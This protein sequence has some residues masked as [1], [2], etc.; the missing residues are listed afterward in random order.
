[1][2]HVCGGVIGY[3]ITPSTEIAEL[4]EAARAEGVLN[5][6]GKHPFFF[7]TEGEHSAQSGAL[8][9]ALTGGQFISNASSSQGILYAMESHFVTVGKKIG[10]FV[11]QVAARVVSKHSLNVMAG[12][13]DVYA[14]LPSGYTILFGSNPQEAADLAAISYRTSALSLIPVANAMDGFAT[15]HVMSEARLPEPEL[16]REYLGDP[17]GRI[18]CPTVAQEMLFGAKGRVFQLATYLDRHA[19]DFPTDDLVALRAYLADTAEKIEQDNAGDLVGETAAWVPAELQP[20][21]RRQWIGAWEKGTRQL[22]PALVD[23]H[24]PGLTGPVQN[25]PDFQAG[26]VDHRTHF[27][28]AVPT[29][30]RQAMAEYSALSGRQYAPVHTYDCDDAD[31]IMVGLG[32]VTDDVRAVLPHLRAQGMKVGVVSVKLLQP[33]PEADLVAALSGAKAVTVLERS[34]DTALTRAVTQALFK[35]RAN[36]DSPQYE[37]IP[38]ISAPPRLTTAVFGLGGHDL[39]PRHTIAAFKQMA[40]GGKSPLLYLGSQFFSKD[41]SPEMAERQARLR[42]AYP[43]TELMALETEPNPAVLP[44]TALRIRFHSVGGYGTIATGKLLTD[45]LAGVLGMHSK[46]APKYGSEKSGAATNYYITLSPEPVLLTNAE[47]EDV[48]VVVSPDH[49][50][51]VHTNPLKGLV[52]GGTFI[53][54]SDL[55]PEDVWR[56]LPAYA[57]KAIRERGIRFLVVDAFAVAKQHAP[58][59]ELETRMMGIA[60]IGAVAGHVDR[61]S[62]GASV[63]AIREKVRE[64][65]VK[66]FG[67]KGEAV[68]EGNMAVIHDGIE[69]THVVDYDAP[70]FVAI[71]AE[72]AARSVRTSALSASMCPTVT[73]ARTSGLFDPAYYEDLIARPFRE[74]TISESPV[75]PGSGLFMPVGTGAAKD[76]GIFRRTAPVFDPAQCTACLECAL[77]CPDV[78]IPNTVHEIHDLLLGGIAAIDATEP[79][80]A[81]LRAQVYPWAERVRELYRQDKSDRAFADVAAEATSVLD[82]KPTLASNAE[83]VVAALAKFPVARTRPYFDAMEAEVPGTGGLFSATIDPWKCTGCLQCVDVCGPGALTAAD[84]DADILTMLEER[85]EVLSGLPNTP[86]RFIEGSTMRDGDIKRLMLDHDNYYA[87]TGGHGACRGCGE[88]TAIRLVTS[89][90]RALGEER[91]TAH[92]RELDDLIERLVAKLGELDPDESVR[93]QRIGSIIGELERSLYL[94]EGGPTGNGPAPTVVANATGCSSVYAS[95]L[96]FTPY[97]DPWVNSLFQD[98]QPLAVGLFEGITAGLVPEVRALRQARLELA[99]DYDEARDAKGL[100]MLS[101][102]AFT[103]DEIA[104][105]P[106]VLTIGG[107]GASYDIGFG[108][109]SRVLASGTPVKVMVLNTGAYS[110]TGGQASTASFIGQD[111]DLARFG[112]AHDG[113]QEGRKELALIA[114]FHPGVFACSTATALHGHFLKATMDL[115]GFGSGAAVMDVYTPC[116]TENG[117]PEDLSN[118][119]SRLAVESRIS[120]VFVHDPRRGD[121]LRERFSLDGNPDVDKTWTTSTLEY[122]DEEGRPQLLTTPLTPAEFA[123]GEVRFK[124]QFRRL[125]ADLEASAVPIAEYVEL[126]PA[127]RTGRAPFVYATDDDRRLIKVACSDSVVALVEDRRR[128]WQT[129]QYISGQAEAQLTAA[130]RAEVD[131]LK[132]QYSEAAKLRE[133]SLD[134]IA[135]AMSDLAVSSK[136]PAGL[137]GTLAGVSVGNG[138]NAAPA[139][140]PPAAAVAVSDLPIHLDPAD[141]ALCTDCGTCY[142]ELPQFFEKVTEIIDG[143][144]MTVAR[145][146][147]GSMDGVE[148]TPDL[149]KRIE[150]VKA[151]CDGEIIK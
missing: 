42:A 22:V 151:T 77:V 110:N 64:Q 41:P 132:A 5:V 36:A 107:D 1:M 17:S 58:T 83:K 118:A 80:R 121:T 65:L 105:L 119:R 103:P 133:S 37:G 20:Q 49:K 47:L 8:G 50:A 79:Q 131:Q 34:D 120:P 91:R 138:A 87:T 116:G 35:A 90:S 82:G 59:P 48:E 128:H 14:L 69:A 100:S 28:S 92:M 113:K 124:K 51:F 129:L 123:L 150:R 144:V 149:A 147:A 85:F 27:A 75:L 106:N 6:W 95:T 94:Y 117:I 136:A 60:F 99:D 13:D 10:G 70:A 98:A 114:A 52:P 45:I 54:Q 104:L 7:E 63:E 84:Q 29:L 43:E 32:S 112:K 68:V 40:D 146:I 2:T 140:T 71:D 72:P 39:Q 102:R 18:V 81:A 66:K 111:A 108:A 57:R 67:N 145:M 97:L 26:A 148:M 115:L 62:T 21:W 109:M 126:S 142:Q 86:K 74:G 76:K 24:N 4:F 96:P 12:H 139:A 73:G 130:H 25:Q 56:A 38:A 101:W 78:A 9:A 141:I 122:V 16:L 44:P 127:E 15:S 3:P 19:D 61:V 89:M 30:V 33:F 46:S 143:Q 53:L 31:Y 93:R 137:G 125:A 134:D 23:P 11:L 55:P 135:R 88:V